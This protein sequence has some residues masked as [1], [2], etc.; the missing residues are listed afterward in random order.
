M[1]KQMACVTLGIALVLGQALPAFALDCGKASSTEDKAICADPQALAADDAMVKAYQALAAT[2]TD[3]TKKTLLQSQRT[4]LKTRANA[5]SDKTGAEKATC[6][7]KATDARR[8][9]LAGATEAGRGSGG[10]LVPVIIEQP[11]GKGQYE[12]DVSLL[13]Y[14]PPTNAAEKLFNAEV[15]ALLRDVEATKNEDLERD[16]SYSYDLHLSMSYASPQLIS[17]HLDGYVFSGGAHGNSISDNINIDVAKAKILAFGDV[18]PTASE[19]KIEAECM[20]QILVQKT[21]RL[22]GEKIE[23]DSLKELR[24]SLADELV[25]LKRWSFASGKATVTFDAYVLGAYVEGA[26]ECGFTTDFLRPL[27]KA[28]F[29]LP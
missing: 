13:K 15:D 22:E 26:Y 7:T 9:Y 29:A 24:Q 3:A 23:G 2:L 5:C 12:L 1:S 10:K 16:L 28:G 18:F 14:T 6:L 20:R 25:K 8:Q 19:P 21:E 17:A 27:A 11:G 4:W